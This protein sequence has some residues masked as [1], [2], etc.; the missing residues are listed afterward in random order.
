M[1]KNAI[2]AAL[3]VA[4]LLGFVLWFFIFRKKEPEPE[5]KP[6]P[7]VTGPTPEPGTTPSETVDATD[8][9]MMG[10]DDEPVPDE[11]ETSLDNAPAEDGVEEET[12]GEVS[13]YM[14]KK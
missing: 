6:E 8:E 12:T 5:P 14:I 10:G 13:P 3:I 4:I 2:I 7:E 9:A 11:D 1:E